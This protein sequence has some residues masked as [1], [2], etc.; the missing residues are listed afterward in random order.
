M[1]TIVLLCSLFVIIFSSC[2]QNI[3]DR[4]VA[5]QEELKI[6]NKESRQILHSYVSSFK[7]MLHALVQNKN[8]RLIWEGHTS[9]IM[10]TL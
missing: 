1:R 3:S 8:F 6:K 10:K 5:D 4:K 9:T 2:Q 7:K